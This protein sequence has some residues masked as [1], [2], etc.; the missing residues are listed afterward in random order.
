MLF[1]ACRDSNP[2]A[3]GVGQ[4]EMQGLNLCRLQ[5]S[6]CAVMPPRLLTVALCTPLTLPYFLTQLW[7]ILEPN[8]ELFIILYSLIRCRLRE[9]E[10][11][12]PSRA[13][14]EQPTLM[15]TS[16]KILRDRTVKHSGPTGTTLAGD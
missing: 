10:S 11:S 6:L 9:M 15:L 12:V 1:V 2:A 5:K 13:D 4:A 7:A 14:L 8:L 3:Q 16:P